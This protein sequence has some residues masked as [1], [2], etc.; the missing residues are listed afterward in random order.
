MPLFRVL[1]Y[2]PQWPSSGFASLDEA[3][4]WVDRFVR[5][6]NTEHRHSKL[7][8]VTP[9]RRHDGEDAELLAQRKAVLEQTRQNNLEKHRMPGSSRSDCAGFAKP[10]HR[11]R[12]VGV[13]RTTSM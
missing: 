5:W 8:F 10:P 11:E 7:N 6:Y 2:R 9:Q 4:V 12:R 1:K 3:R 13:S